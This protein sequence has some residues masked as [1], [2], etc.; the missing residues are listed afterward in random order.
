MNLMT[1]LAR[2]SRP[3]PNTIRH[4]TVVKVHGCFGLGDTLY[5]RPIVELWA[6]TREPNT[7]YV[8][9]P[10]PQLWAGTSARII[11]SNTHLRTQI[12]NERRNLHLYDHPEPAN[13]KRL[14]MGYNIADF[15]R[16]LTVSDAIAARLQF[17]L[18]DKMEHAFI[19]PDEWKWKPETNKPIAFVRPPTVRKE[20]RAPGRN[21]D[22][23]A[24]KA[25]VN[26]LMESHHVISVA[27]IA[28]NEEWIVDEIPAHT[29]YEH[30]ELSTEQAFGLMASSDIVLGGVGFIVPAVGA[31]NIRTFILA[32]GV[33][34][35]NCEHAL[36]DRRFNWKIRFAYPDEGSQCYCSKY[37]HACVK[38][39][40]P[41]RVVGE[42]ESFI[43]EAT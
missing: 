32:G 30:G 33:L 17:T 21:P 34:K 18:P 6:A 16:G 9:T 23:A 43:R 37:E 22:P 8:H 26:R 4:D 11:P 13:A 10:W 38:K 20:W 36:C 29:R 28:K 31:T 7:T 35:G 5:L 2:Q 1:L 27:H 42:L 40:D 14:A 3:N 12:E 39:T 24:F 41:A 19:V 25:L 15:D